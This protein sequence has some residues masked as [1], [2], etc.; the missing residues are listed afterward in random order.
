MA[1][2]NM[3]TVRGEQ[4]QQQRMC[5]SDGDR[6]AGTCIYTEVEVTEIYRTQRHSTIQYLQGRDVMYC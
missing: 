4:W 1:T 6:K 2:V 3:A 5:V